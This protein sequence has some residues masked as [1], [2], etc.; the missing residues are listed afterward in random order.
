MRILLST[1]AL[2][3][4]LAAC[5]RKDNKPYRHTPVAKQSNNQQLTDKAVLESELDLNEY[6]LIGSRFT[7]TYL[8][9]HDSQIYNVDEQEE[10]ME[11]LQM[12]YQK[13]GSAEEIV[14]VSLPK[15]PQHLSAINEDYLL[16]SRPSYDYYDSATYTTKSFPADGFLINSKTGS[17]WKIE[18]FM[19]LPG[20]VQAVSDG[21]HK[22]LVFIGRRSN[23]DY[24][25]CADDKDKELYNWISDESF[26]SSSLSGENDVVVSIDYTD[27]SQVTLTPLTTA[28]Q[29]E[30]ILK[31]F[32]DQNGNILLKTEFRQ[33]LGDN[34]YT[35]T[36]RIYAIVQNGQSPLINIAP[37]LSDDQWRS[38]RLHQDAL[39]RIWYVKHNYTDYKNVIELYQL[40]ITIRQGRAVVDEQLVGS[41]S[42]EN[43]PY[44]RGDVYSQFIHGNLHIIV[45]DTVIQLNGATQEVKAYSDGEY[46]QYV[47]KTIAHETSGQL[48]N[49]YRLTNSQFHQFKVFH[50]ASMEELNIDSSMLY[51]EVLVE[52][53]HEDELG[54]VH[55]TMVEADKVRHYSYHADI[56]QIKLIKTERRDVDNRI[57]ILVE[58]KPIN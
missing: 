39:G 11:P 58:V 13:N 43:T 54:V 41:A 42:L 23:S 38:S 29:N 16:L 55:F 21:F 46:E 40:S 30:N 32:F 24:Q 15:R 33:S 20:S 34:S 6:S 14:V 53:I 47:I 31:F 3:C 50:T 9:I 48:L 10:L 17:S 25:P 4:S 1:L 57:R 26:C 7:G 37:T 18:D 22:K 12:V 49:W 56:L 2:S 35:Y 27:L 28:I 5:D 45:G 8:T 51:G 44:F 36:D 52:S 19:P